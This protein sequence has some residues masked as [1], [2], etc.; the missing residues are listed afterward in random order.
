MLFSDKGGVLA[1]VVE[2]QA[3]L[4]LFKGASSLSVGENTLFLG[5][6]RHNHWSVQTSLASHDSQNVQFG[7]T[8][9]GISAAGG[10]LFRHQIRIRAQ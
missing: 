3:W 6:H 9:V 2:I 10:V 7:I 4:T 5:V 8:Q 1:L